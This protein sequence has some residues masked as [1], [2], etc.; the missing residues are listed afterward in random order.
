MSGRYNQAIEDYTSAL[1]L[2]PNLTRAYA[3]R[4]H[5]HRRLRHHDAAL[6]DFGQAIRLAPDQPLHLINRGAAPQS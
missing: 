5:A 6:A 4:G 2:D 1:S 3:G